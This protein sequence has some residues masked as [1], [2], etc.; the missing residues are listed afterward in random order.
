M[1]GLVNRRDPVH[2]QHKASFPRAFILGPHIFTQRL[3]TQVSQKGMSMDACGR[4][5]ASANLD[6]ARGL[7]RAVGG[8]VIFGL[9][10]LM[11]MEMWTLGMSVPPLRLMLFLALN[12]AI[13][14]RLSRF[15]GFEPTSSMTEDLLDALAAYAVGIVVAAFALAIFG[16]IRFDMRSDE[17]TAMVAVQAVPTSFGAMLARKQLS[18]GDIEK[19]EEQAAI[20][21]SYGA[22]LFLMLAGALFLALNIAP[23]E[24]ISLIAYKMSPWHSLVLLGV[25]VVMLHLLVFTVGFAGQEQRP[26]GYGPARIFLTF[27]APGYAIAALASLYVLWTFGTADGASLEA[28]AGSVIVLSFPASIGAAVARLVV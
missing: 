26:L 7:G 19:S 24:E 3:R 4:E 6:Y 5:S 20:N 10:L 17:L 13:L 28:L 22:Q 18:S 12:F 25:S 27:T 15:G 8:A 16:L 1:L 11:T 21:Q 9:P 14:V 23:T 2:S